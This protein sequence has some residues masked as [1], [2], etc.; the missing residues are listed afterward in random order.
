MSRWQADGAFSS[1]HHDW[2]TPAEFFELLNDEFEFTLDAAAS[3]HNAKVSNYFTKEDDALK[4]DWAKAAGK[5]GAVFI[6]PPYGRKIGQWIEKAAEEGQR[7]TVV[8]LVFAR[9]DVKWFHDHIM[10]KATEL[11]LIRGRLSF[12]REG[13]KGTAPAPS[14]IVVWRPGIRVTKHLPAY[15]SARQPREATK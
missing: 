8:A 1:K 3:A 4:Q 5:G 2:Q 6:N 10:P 15:S 13:R 11:R 7:V 12:T 9:T 14:M